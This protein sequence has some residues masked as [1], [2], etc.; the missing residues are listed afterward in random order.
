MKRDVNSLHTEKKVAMRFSRSV[1]TI[2]T[3]LLVLVGPFPSIAARQASLDSLAD[4]SKCMQTSTLPNDLA[5][6]PDGT[7][8]YIADFVA[9]RVIVAMTRTNTVKTIISLPGS[10]RGIA[11]SPDGKTAYAIVNRQG[12]AIFAIDTEGDYING[13]FA[14]GRGSYHGIVIS[15]DGRAAYLLRFDPYGVVKINLATGT[16]LSS[17]QLYQAALREILDPRGLKLYV[18]GNAL[19]ELDTKTLRTIH[20]LDL[21]EDSQGIATNRRGS[22]IAIVVPSLSGGLYLFDPKRNAVGRRISVGSLPD[23]AVF[24]P[25]GKSVFITN[26]VTGRGILPNPY[27]HTGVLV[28]GTLGVISVVDVSSARVVATIPVGLGPHQLTIS[29]DGS[30]LYTVVFDHALRPS[31]AVVDTKKR[32]ISAR[33]PI[34]MATTNSSR[35]MNLGRSPICF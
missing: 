2:S 22:K 35:T 19:R 1:V 23:A 16:P 6:T 29:P 24:S 27:S 13:T 4:F 25:D 3:I 10:V 34:P 14:L 33:I 8:L 26:P 31:V 9:G 5:I 17:R 32:N 20:K 28:S 12:G 21:Q 15:S 11:V 30:R 7:K 18:T